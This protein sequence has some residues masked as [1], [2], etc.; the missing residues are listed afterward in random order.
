MKHFR[1]IPRRKSTYRLAKNLDAVSRKAM[2]VYEASEKYET[3]KV[4]IRK[5]KVCRKKSIVIVKTVMILHHVS[6]L[7][8][9]IF[10]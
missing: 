5:S 9:K 10:F 3:Q 2:L 6:L 7:K 1:V 8:E 4:R